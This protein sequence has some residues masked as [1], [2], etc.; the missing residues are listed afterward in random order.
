M[1]QSQLPAAGQ[2]AALAS[3]AEA[4]ELVARLAQSM[5]A[6]LQIV[7][8]E[9][10]LVRAGKLADAGRLE[11][12]KADYARR[13]L[14]DIELMKANAPFLSRT[15]PAIVDELRKGHDLFRAAL[16]VNLTVLA[17][18][19]AV[20]EGIIRGVAAEVNEQAAPRS[21]APANR[22]APRQPQSRPIAVSRSL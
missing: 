14:R 16:Q 20:S 15:I 6:L 12:L 17:T 4:E 7:D 18:A 10:R 22:P 5:N 8:E 2:P 11:Q 3:R 19:Q 13:Y 21:Y 9:T 1:S